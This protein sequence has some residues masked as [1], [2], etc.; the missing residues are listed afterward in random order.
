MYIM[1]KGIASIILNIIQI[2]VKNIKYTKPIPIPIV[3][4][5]DPI[6]NIYKG[7]DIQNKTN[8]FIIQLMRLIIPSIIIKSAI[9]AKMMVTTIL[10]HSILLIPKS[11]I[12]SQH[13]EQTID[14]IL[15]FLDNI[16]LCNIAE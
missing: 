16:R 9:I 2:S 11:T 13:R 4:N 6:I 1:I 8:C 3:A 12:M 5:I 10:A 15:F 7:G 14:K